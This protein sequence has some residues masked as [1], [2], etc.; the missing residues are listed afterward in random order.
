MDEI[1]YLDIGQMAGLQFDCSCGRKHS[2]DIRRIAVGSGMLPEIAAILAPFKEGKLFL[3]AD[4]NTYAVYGRKVEQT[5]SESGFRL[6]SFVFP[7]TEMLVPDEKALGRLLIE[8]DK[9]SSAIVAV[10]S[11][12]LND[13]ARVL[14]HKLDIPYLI[15]GTAPSM[16]GYASV[17]SPLIIE[18]FKTTYEGVYP[19]AVVA[20]LDVMA[21][22]PMEMIHAGFGDVLGKLTALADWRLSRE[23]NGEYY[24]PTSAT[25]V[26][27]AL[28]K[29]EESAEG[30]AK[31]DATAIR[32]LTEALILTGVAMGLVGNSRPASGAEHHLAHYWEMDALAK[33]MEHPL[34]GNS[35]GAATAAIA[36]VYELLAAE[37]SVGPASSGAG[38]SSLPF[39]LNYPSS[40]RIGE[41]LKKAGACPD[42][43]LLGIDR[44]L[45]RQSLLH[46]MEIRERY[47]VLR[48][49]AARG[50]LAQMTDTLVCKYYKV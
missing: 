2:V 20:D 1:L 36:S 15:A 10:G 14:S 46:A 29:C 4:R 39:G 8:I 31:R 11:G 13:L 33:G 22:A 45:F 7:N 21:Q 48:F 24:C 47:S 41:F 37:S 35:V 19:Y 34:H 3:M 32:Y 9:G 26:E 12:S 38:A 16:D 25:L 49:A 30:L 5:L 23:L 6:R 27:S 17:V 18:G 28:K 40:A 42:P 43:A 50:K 44:E